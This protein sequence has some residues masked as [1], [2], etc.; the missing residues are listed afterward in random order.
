MSYDKF[1]AEVVAKS[2]AL[3][4]VISKTQVCDIAIAIEGM[5]K[6]NK[7]AMLEELFDYAASSLSI[8][9]VFL[10]VS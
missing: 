9:S 8:S 3:T 6:Q 10:K 4:Y 1:H 7:D 2:N 5:T